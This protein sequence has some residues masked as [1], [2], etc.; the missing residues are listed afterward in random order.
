MNDITFQSLC[1]DVKCIITEAVHLSRWELIVGYH[2]VGERLRRDIN[3]IENARG[4]GGTLSALSK[5][6]EVNE[7][8]LYRAMQFYDKYPSLDLLPYGKNISWNKIV[9]ELLP[10]LPD[11]KDEPDEQEKRGYI[12]ISAFS[13]L[14]KLAR[15]WEPARQAEYQADLNRFKSKWFN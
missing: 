2:K 6:I 13:G 8:T 15:D 7:R 4:N 5:S 1:E 14:M 12:V 3:P 11:G 10:A 9:T